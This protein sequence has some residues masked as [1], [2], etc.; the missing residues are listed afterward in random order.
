MPW[1]DVT[2]MEQKQEMIEKWKSGLYSKMELSRMLGVSRPTLDKWICRYESQGIAGLEDRSTRP[3][4]SPQRIDDEVA[5]RLL[6]LKRTETNWGPAKILDWLNKNE[7]QQS[8]PA[9]STVGDLLA[10]HGLVEK[11]RKRRRVAGGS[12]GV[13]S[14]SLSSGEMMTVDYK[15]EFRLGNGKYC[16]PLTI[17]DPVSRYTYAID[18]HDGTKFRKAKKSFERVFSEYGF[19]RWIKSDNGGPFS[20]PA[21]GGISRLSIWWIKLEIEPIRI[22]KGSPW[23]NGRHERMHK[24]LKQETTRPPQKNMKGQQRCF[25]RFKKSYNEDRPHEALDGDVPSEHLKRSGR[26]YPSRIPAVEYPYHF[27][28]RK[29]HPNGQIKLHNQVVFLSEVLVGEYVGLEEVDDD[30]W[31]IYFSNFELGRWSLREGVVV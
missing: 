13:V 4:K 1:K 7:P 30:V 18:G 26:P 31:S 2:R 27:E 15:G 25:D 19:P 9:V 22:P 14:E 20:S 28:V 21:I 6:D 3:K 16:Y 23:Q 11:R 17:C 24:T 12:A 29:V 10:R 8:W 5:A